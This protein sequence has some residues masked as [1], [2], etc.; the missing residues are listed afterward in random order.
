MGQ[1]GYVA[2][3]S[4]V[5]R[6]WFDA[7]LAGDLDTA[8]TLLAPEARIRVPDAELQGFDELMA[9]YRARRDSHPSF[10]YEVLDILGGDRHAAAVI[11]LTDENT[12]WRQVAL[13]EVAD[14]R[15]VA[16]SAYED[17]P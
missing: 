8:R 16:M 9:W 12:E 4:E 2:D 14:G 7:H 10:E 11:R 5:L 3:T 13:Y 15:I 6:R 17:R 1:T